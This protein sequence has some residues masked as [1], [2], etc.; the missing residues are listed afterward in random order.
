LPPGA[1]RFNSTTNHLE[2]WNGNQWIHT[3]YL[4]QNN[5]P[6]STISNLVSY[7]PLND[8]SFAGGYFK[9]YASGYHLRLLGPGNTTYTSEISSSISVVPDSRFGT[10]VQFNRDYNNSYLRSES[11]RTL[12][13]GSAM[14]VSFWFRSDSTLNTG[15]TGNQ[16]VISEG[17]VNGRWNIFFEPQL[18][19]RPTGG[20]DV[21]TSSQNY[22]DGNWHNAVLTHNGSS[23]N[24]VNIYIDGKLVKTGASIANTFQGNFLLVGQHSSLL[25]NVNSYYWRGWLTQRRIYDKVLSQSEVNTL[26][27]EF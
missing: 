1:S 14:S 20:G 22:L 10:V 4:N 8:E 12:A 9:D 15:T 11:W 7:W 19:W 25:G 6:S 21:Q 24:I 26:Y 23:G 27:G 2:I 18:K 17:P 5:V 3:G 13:S 16:W